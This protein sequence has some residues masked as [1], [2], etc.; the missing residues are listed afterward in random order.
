MLMSPM[1]Q[2]GSESA[3]EAEFSIESRINLD[4]N[5]VTVKATNFVNTSNVPVGVPIG[6]IMMWGST[7][8][9]DGWKLCHGGTYDINIYPELYAVL[10]TATLPDMRGRFPLG[11]STTGPI[12]ATI[13]TSGG[14]TT[15][16]YTTVTGHTHNMNAFNASTSVT[17]GTVDTNNHTHSVTGNTSANTAHIV[18]GKQIGRAHV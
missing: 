7:S 4:V 2:A 15:Y 16:S 18:T 17:E 12:P 1:L 6:S 5:E 13:L 8:A 11:A 10:G 14:T 3:T 9:P